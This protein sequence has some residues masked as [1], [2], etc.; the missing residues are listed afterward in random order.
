MVFITQIQ[1]LGCLC[2]LLL[3]VFFGG[4]IM[5]GQMFVIGVKE[6]GTVVFFLQISF[7]SN[8]HCVS[9]KPSVCA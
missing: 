2:E 1:V 3:Y 4:G 8:K 5:G 6:G 7:E 9:V